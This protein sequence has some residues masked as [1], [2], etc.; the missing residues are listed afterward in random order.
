MKPISLTYRNTAFDIPNGWEQLTPEQ[1][2]HLV[3]NILLASQGKLSPGEVRMRYVC[4]V[5]GWN[6]GKFRTEDQLENLVVLSQMVSFIFLITYPK[7][8]EAVARLTD[9]EYR[10]ARRTD[11]FHLSFP[12]AEDLRKEDY[13]Y[14]VDWCFCKQLVPEVSVGKRVFTGYEIN[15]GFGMLTTSLTALQY[16]EARALLG[17]GADTLPL[18]ASILYYPGPYDSEDAHRK[19]D[20]FSDVPQN[21]L[22]AIA[23]NFT[24]FNN[25]LMT[26]TEYSILTEFTSQRARE[27]STDAADALYDL[28]SDGLGDAQHVERLNLLTY[29]RILRKKTIESVRRLSAAGEDPGKIANTTGLDVTTIMKIL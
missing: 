5:M 22:A 11:P 1:Y 3:D 17:N 7:D 9:E 27:I 29:L 14:E 18:L 19:A 20:L 4:D 2:Q 13:R 24:A 12:H 16:I 25:F 6:I 21:V 26:K 15:T 28:S 8:S 10:E 23:Y